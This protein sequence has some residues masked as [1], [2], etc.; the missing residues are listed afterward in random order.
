MKNTLPIIYNGGAY[1]TYLEWALR[2]LGTSIPIKSPLTDVGNSHNTSTGFQCRGMDEWRRYLLRD[3]HE[4]TVRVHPKTHKDESVSKNIE[5]ILNSCEKAILIYPDIDSELLCMNNYMTKVYPRKDIYQGPLLDLDL[6]QIYDNFPISRS[7]PIPLWIRREHLSFYLVPAWRDQINWFLPSYWTN[8][9][10]LIIFVKELLFDFKSVIEKI[11]K[12]W[13]L[14]FIKLVD[15]LLPIHQQMLL[16]QKHVNQDSICRSIIESVT[17]HGHDMTW[18][19][20][21]LTSES[22]IQ[23]RLRELGYEIRCHDLDVF[24]N[25]SKSLQE[26]MYRP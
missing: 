6:S 11:Q 22:W 9:R 5:E 21:P 25:D 20:L 1:G 13:K 26:L 15:E 3:I 10:C 24:P 7:E 2:T 4:L 17:L 8:D 18:A 12:F 23:W 19:N 16:L 14:D